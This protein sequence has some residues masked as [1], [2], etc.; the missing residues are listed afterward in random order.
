MYQEAS[1]VKTTRPNLQNV[2]KRN[3]F[4][5]VLDICR[6]KPIIWLSA[7]PGAGKTTLIS[8]YVESRKLQCLWYQI[9][10]GDTDLATFFHYLGL[11]SAKANPKRRNPLPHL[12]PEYLPGLQ[13]FA[14][15]YFL[16]LYKNLNKKSLIVFDNYQEAPVES[17]LHEVLHAGLCAVPDN[18]NV[19]IISRT[20]PPSVLSRMRLRELMEVI[21]YDDLRLTATEVRGI[22]A[23]RGMKK[24]SEMEIS[25]LLS[26]TEGWMAGLILMLESKNIGDYSSEHM[27]SYN[28]AATFQY[29]A[30][31]FFQKLD[32]DIRD[33]LLKLSVFSD[34]TSGMAKELTGNI[35]AERIIS[36]LAYKNYFLQCRAGDQASYQF[37]PLFRE[38]LYTRLMDE[39]SPDIL[40]ELERNAAK[41]DID[42][43]HV[44]DA[45]RL[46]H[47][48]SD[49]DSLASLICKETPMFLEQ[50]RHQTI[51]AW[52]NYLPDQVIKE[53]P[54][55]MFWKAACLSPFD[56]SISRQLLEMSYEVFYNRK[57]PCGIFLSWAGIIKAIV[58]EFDNFKL[59][60]R[61]I[62]LLDEL[63][64][65]YPS[66]PS[67]E[68]EV[69]VSL[70]MFV[71]LSFRE[72]HHPDMSR[73]VDKTF[74]L[75]NEA[76]FS[77]VHVQACL[78]LVDYFIW[79]GE[80]KKADIIV[81][82]FSKTINKGKYPPY[83][84]IST[85]LAESLNNWHHGRL[86]ECIA[87]V[88][89]GLEIADTT[90]V[91][92]FNYFLYGHGAVCSFTG[93]DL[94]T[95]KTY[96]EKAGAT[97]DD[98]KRFCLSY[99][100][101]I[102]ACHTFLKKDLAGALEHEQRALSL[103]VV[104]GSPFAEG[105]A[106][107]GVAL[108]HYELGDRQ[109]ADVEITNALNLAVKTN[110]KLIEFVC[111]L[112]E[113]YFALDSG[114]KEL[115]TEKLRVAMVL[116][117][118]KGF[119]NFHMWRPDIMAR[120]CV[121]ALDEGME[122]EYIQRLI[123]KRD[124][125]LDGKTLTVDRWPWRVKIFILGGL[126]IYKDGVLLKFNRKAPK[127]PLEM[128]KLLITLGGREVPEQK[129]SDVL[130]EDADGDSAYDAFNTT[131]K[132]L[133]KLIG[134]DNAILF[135]N[136]RLTLNSRYCWVDVW[137]F[138]RLLKE[139]NMSSQE[140]LDEASVIRIEKAL[141]IYGK[142]F[143]IEVGDNP[144]SMLFN[145]R[146]KSKFIRSVLKLSSHWEKAGLFEK[147][148]EYYT[149]GIEIDSLSE[150]LYQKF[151]V[152]LDKQG[153]SAEALVVYKRLSEILSQVL[154]TEPSIETTRIYN[155][156][157][158]S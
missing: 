129:I 22:V 40:A 134:V 153:K 38:F 15:E 35:D 133:R 65:E 9:D 32:D 27:D 51:L 128:L 7:P 101:H 25:S 103:A 146:I 57:D 100:H 36:E 152:C 95:A 123:S 149:K 88:S 56:Q 2:Y 23:L 5:D 150:E 6:K 118:K 61:W 12:T 85:K 39:V 82:M 147:A 148:I 24:A 18:V 29:F 107:T 55:L 67:K 19:I 76:S 110:S 132:R 52:L 104:V 70:S 135:S 54:W 92:I 84:L 108:L 30:D 17:M 90:G 60:D 11:A 8:S 111:Y 143:N 89:E 73:W 33:F 69:D 127:K 46:F 37:H 119:V 72:P 45:V 14:Q 117:S 157:I 81:E 120:L 98:R 21:T 131:L 124:L 142:G 10:S 3:N 86:Q 97:L 140:V 114:S 106:R 87:S 102:V 94:K 59:L 44:D 112:F 66:F 53:I 68:I 64:T 58:Q 42:N 1:F 71:A 137:A 63:L 26:R 113:A 13:K 34:M 78:S 4:F 93:G 91:N 121:L 20:V 48:L 125:F 154:D 49:W 80:L 62:N 16:K 96:L 50:G 130:W 141:E 83:A 115:A 31:E 28:A 43:G 155:R 144:L 74:A 151:M 47:K 138:E 99:Y 75:L 139:A 116:G 105:M 158:A 41:I 126:S 156:L 136:G 77:Q 109:T 145:K 79:T 122:V